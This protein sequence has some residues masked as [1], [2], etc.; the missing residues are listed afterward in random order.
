[1]EFEGIY[2]EYKKPLMSLAHRLNGH[3]GYIS[4]DD[5]F[6]E[7]TAHLW[8]RWQKGELTDKTKSYII[9]SCYFHVKNYIRVYADKPFFVSLDEPVDEEGSQLKDMLPDKSQGRDSIFGAACTDE[10]KEMDMTPREKEVLD[11]WAEARTTRDIGQT[12]GI[13]HVR[14]IKIQESI[15]KKYLKM[16]YQKPAL[17]TL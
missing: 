7:M 5:L 1:M 2:K 10:I 11:L 4:D 12:L 9:K 14:V 15:K 16:G 3:L 8:T 6:Q 13:S 17:F